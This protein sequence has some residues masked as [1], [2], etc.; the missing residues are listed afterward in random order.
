M[1]QRATWTDVAFVGRA[2]AN[3]T[4]R[5]SSRARLTSPTA[6]EWQRQ[7]A[8]AL[9]DILGDPSRPIEWEPTWR[10]ETVTALATGIHFDNAFD[11]LPIL[12]DALEEAGCDDAEV[13]ADVAPA[14]RTAPPWTVSVPE[15]ETVVVPSAVELS[16]TSELIALPVKPV[17]EAVVRTL[18]VGPAAA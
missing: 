8:D 10:S 14:N 15:P 7:Q 16:I 12:A 3:G 6:D 1:S 2:E 17:S 5:V 9:R 18:S 13:L 11:R 4:R